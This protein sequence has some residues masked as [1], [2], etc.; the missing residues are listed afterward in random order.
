[1]FYLFT[2]F[3]LINRQ[4][5]DLNGRYPIQVSLDSYHRY[6]LERDQKGNRKQGKEK[7]KRQNI[8]RIKKEGKQVPNE[9]RQFGIKEKFRNVGATFSFLFRSALMSESW[10]KS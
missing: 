4:H 6:K 2:L 10:E 8:A 1:M 5:Y 9:K 3:L 7:G